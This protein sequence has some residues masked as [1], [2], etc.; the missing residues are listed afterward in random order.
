M[1]AN[2]FENRAYLGGPAVKGKGLLP[3]DYWYYG[4]ES[5]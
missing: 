1:Y 2:S 5:C 3:L 4:F